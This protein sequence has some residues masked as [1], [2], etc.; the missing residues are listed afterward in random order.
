MRGAFDPPVFI[1]WFALLVWIGGFDLIYACRDLE[2]DRRAGLHSF[3]A[4]FGI[5][6]ALCPAKAA[7]NTA[8]CG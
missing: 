6:P 2:F 4:R 1:L 3:P 8:A 7:Y 5:A